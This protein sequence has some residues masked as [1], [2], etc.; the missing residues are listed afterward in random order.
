MSAAAKQGEGTTA[1]TANSSKMCSEFANKTLQDYEVLA[2]M[3]NGAFGTCYKVKDK[4][5]GEL[6]AWKGM[7]YDELDDEKCESLISEISVLRQLQHPN[8]VQYYHHLVNR[9]AKSIYIVMECCDGG[10]LAQLIQRARGQRQRFEE[11]YIW[12][13]LFQLCRALQVCHN[14][15]PSGTILHRDIKPANIFLDVAGNVKLGDFGLARVLR[16]DQ[17]FAASFVGTP[18]YMSP[19]LVKG[20]QY[21]RKSDVWAVGCLIYELC[22]LRPPFRGRAFAQLSENIAHGEFSAIPGVYSQDLQSIIG[23]MLA[24]D[25]EQRPS[26]EVIT[27]HPLLVRNISQLDG[28]FP[29]LV[30]ADNDFPA[31]VGKLFMDTEPELSSTMFTEQYSFNEGYGQRRL[32]V[33]GVFTPD[34][35]S[36]LFYSAK[37]RIF[38]SKQLLQSDP[39]LYESIQRET[40]RDRETESK[41]A[42]SAVEEK[43]PRRITQHIFD[44]AL[45]QRL[46]A[47]RAQESLLEQRANELQAAEL[48]VQAMERELLQKLEQVEAQAQAQKQQQ[49]CQCQRKQ[50]PP[51]AIP[52]RKPVTRHDDT[53]CSIEL[54]ETSPTVAKLNLAMLTAPKQLHSA[55]SSSIN[56][57]NNTLRK[58]TFQSPPKLSKVAAT[59]SQPSVALPM[60]TSVSSN[61]SGDSQAS[62]TRR[63][64]ILALF[65][66]SRA[67]K[68]AVAKTTTTTTSAPEQAQRRQPLAVK[69]PASQQ[70]APP[71]APP[72]QQQ[73]LTNMWTKEQKRAAFDLLAAMNAAEKDAASVA[74]PGRR[75]QMRQSV[76]ERNSSLQRNRMRRS[77]VLGGSSGGQSKPLLVASR[78]Q[79]LI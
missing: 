79:M 67:P 10:D 37:R 5:T 75:Q 13:V 14:Q 9:E 41:R 43:S 73:Q 11:P 6:Y 40:E 47:I 58:V 24:V 44:D 45:Q 33:S 78:E 66:L 69:P 62:S 28:E 74:Q 64:S 1:T 25:H 56:N 30:A 76:R 18:H 19:E 54:N 77:L 49:P 4:T 59:T 15:I 48:R 63:K 52:P 57:N 38:A 53:Y 17:S 55:T 71:P 70:L 12:R 7:N 31:G 50:L 2:V 42:G 23:F 60:Q 61:E 8:I 16:R 35:R 72:Q 29:R 3:G 34:L 26:I 65:G 36:E 51:P 46:H 27:R 39:S 32:S 21:D 22:A 68:A 20:R